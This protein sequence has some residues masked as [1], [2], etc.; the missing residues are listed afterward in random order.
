[1]A[2]KIYRV[3]N[4]RLLEFNL[5]LLTC[6]VFALDDG[7]PTM[8]FTYQY[9]LTVM[10]LMLLWTQFRRRNSENGITS[11]FDLC[12]FKRESGW[13]VMDAFMFILCQLQTSQL[14]VVSD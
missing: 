13:G 3:I 2:S 4:V 10:G 8:P 14:T 12:E 1:M 7:F 9:L 6:S 5:L 11:H